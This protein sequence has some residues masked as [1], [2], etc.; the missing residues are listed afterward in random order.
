MRPPTSGKNFTT[1][2]LRQ[3]KETPLNYGFPISLPVGVTE[4]QS[5]RLQRHSRSLSY[6]QEL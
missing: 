4:T 3:T 6:V 1:I 5:P 2:L